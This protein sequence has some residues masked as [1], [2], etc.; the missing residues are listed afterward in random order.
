MSLFLATG[1]V[2][3]PTEILLLYPAMDVL[4]I[5]SDYTQV[6]IVYYTY[7]IVQYIGNG[8]V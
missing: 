8:T 5:I 7:D 2:F 6:A 3:E 1:P 4:Y